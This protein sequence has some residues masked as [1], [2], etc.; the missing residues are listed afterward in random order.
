MPIT[1]IDNTRIGD[2]KPGPVTK[3]IMR[4]FGEYTG[5]ELPY[6]P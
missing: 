4:L 5:R 1:L 3:M 6:E 2:G